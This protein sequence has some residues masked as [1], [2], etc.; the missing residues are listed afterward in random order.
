MDFLIFTVMSAWSDE[1]VSTCYTLQ[2]FEVCIKP[3]WGVVLDLDRH[4]CSCALGS[5]LGRLIYHFHKLCVTVIKN[6]EVLLLQLLMWSLLSHL[7]NWLRLPNSG[8]CLVSVD[9][10]HSVQYNVHDDFSSYSTIT[11]T[12]AYPRAMYIMDLKQFTNK[13]KAQHTMCAA[14]TRENWRF[15]W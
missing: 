10:L 4:T 5:T 15:R 3:Q 9:E 11:W 13:H 12:T 14:R 6:Q 8:Q 1:N 2:F 7:T